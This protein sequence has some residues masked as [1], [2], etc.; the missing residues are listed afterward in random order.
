MTKKSWP[1]CCTIHR[2]GLMSYSTLLA[3][4]I[5]FYFTQLLIAYPAYTNS[6]C[7]K[8]V[9]EEKNDEHHNS[10]LPAECE[11]RDGKNFETSTVFANRAFSNN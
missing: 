7:L 8:G 3:G 11:M 1:F 4:L 2:N 9:S 10:T 6:Y 5:Y